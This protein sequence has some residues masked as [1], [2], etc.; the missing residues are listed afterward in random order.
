MFN[1]HAK[2]QGAAFGKNF[3]AKLWLKQTEHLHSN[4][5]LPRPLWGQPQVGYH[6]R[7]GVNNASQ[8]LPL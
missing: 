6:S 2:M 4:A 1:G 8:P 3:A 5:A 7:H